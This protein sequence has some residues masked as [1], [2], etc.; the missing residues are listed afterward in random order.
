MW[1]HLSHNLLVRTL[2]SPAQIPG[3]GT[4]PHLLVGRVT[5]SVSECGRWDTYI[6]V[7]TFE[8]SILVTISLCMCVANCHVVHLK[9]MQF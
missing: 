3:E 7:A 1:L 2:T 6:F 9:H 5:V 4:A 8:K